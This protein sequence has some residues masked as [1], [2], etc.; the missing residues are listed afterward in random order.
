MLILINTNTVA[1]VFDS[2]SYFFITGQYHGKKEKVIISE[3]D[4]NSSVH[5]Y[6]KGKNILILGEG[7]TQRLDDPTLT[8]E[9]KYSINLTQPHRELCWV[10]IIMGATGVCLLMVQKYIN[11]K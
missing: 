6:N 10:Y 3:G 5:N 2:R 7:P 4:M 1:A 8:V 9:V 11:F